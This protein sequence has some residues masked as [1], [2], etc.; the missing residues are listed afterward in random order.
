MI[1]TC[2]PSG[3]VGHDSVTLRGLPVPDLAHRDGLFGI[4]EQQ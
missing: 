1:A 2:A 3:K 4:I